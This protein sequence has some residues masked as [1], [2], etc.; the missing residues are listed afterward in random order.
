MPPFWAP[1]SGIRLP[2]KKRVAL[3]LFAL[4]VVAGDVVAAAVALQRRVR[5]VAAHAVATR[6]VAPP[7]AG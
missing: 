5:V 4:G 2:E 6:R 7:S 1:L 3:R